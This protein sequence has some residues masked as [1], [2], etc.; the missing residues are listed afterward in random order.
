MEA[1]EADAAAFAVAVR[2]QMERNSSSTAVPAVSSTW[3]PSHSTATSRPVPMTTA[4]PYIP[5]ELLTTPVVS[6]N[7]SSVNP[8]VLFTLK[9]G[10]DGAVASVQV[11]GLGGGLIALIVIAVLLFLC[12]ALGCFGR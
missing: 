6:K 2:R 11:A 4:T 3:V 1:E 10:T 9:G 8:S 12:L 5:P 7:Q